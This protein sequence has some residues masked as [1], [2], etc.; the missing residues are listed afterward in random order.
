MDKPDFEFDE[1]AAIKKWSDL[2][3][4][5]ELSDEEF[6][7]AGYFAHSVILDIARYQHSIDLEKHKE[8]VKHLREQVSKLL[9]SVEQFEPL[10]KEIA[11][12]KEEVQWWMKKAHDKECLIVD[13][14]NYVVREKSENA[15]LKEQNAILIEALK[16]IAD[17]DVTYYER[18]NKL[19]VRVPPYFEIAHEALEKVGVE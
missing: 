15:K 9:D 11:T 10:Y 3:K 5:R 12:L 8:I 19:G 14:E 4:E 18:E 1:D 17:S 7:T 13:W 16:R 6:I 2:I